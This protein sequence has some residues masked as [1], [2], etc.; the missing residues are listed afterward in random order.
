MSKF[1]VACIVLAIFCFLGGFIQG[2]NG[3]RITQSV[4][5]VINVLSSVLFIASVVIAILSKEYLGILWLFA[6]YCVCGGI[7]M[8]AGQSLWR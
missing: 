1:T 2:L 4:R 5:A 7:G 3:S 6:I 8:Y